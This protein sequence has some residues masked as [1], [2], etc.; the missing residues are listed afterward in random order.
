[1]ADLPLDLVFTVNVVSPDKRQQRPRPLT[2]HYQTL[3]ALPGDCEEP[4][5]RSIHR[6]PPFLAPVYKDSQALSFCFEYQRIYTLARTITYKY[7]DVNGKIFNC[8]DVRPADY[9]RRLGLI[10]LISR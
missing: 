2:S 7:V 9:L 10:P 1:L 5:L 8:A 4:F 3:R 6:I